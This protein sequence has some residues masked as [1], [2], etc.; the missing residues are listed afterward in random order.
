GPFNA[1]LYAPEIGDAAQSLGELLRF[2]GVLA[3]RLRELAILTV[4]AHWRAQYE[5]WAH[6]KIARVEGLEN[7]IIEA[8]KMGHAVAGDDGAEIVHLFVSELLKDR[9]VSDR[10]FQ[11]VKAELG[12]EALVE[13][14]VLVGY[15]GLIAA[16]LNVFQVPLPEGEEPPFPGE[17]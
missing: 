15:Y 12:D 1:F 9:N 14:V 16:T 13:L 10:T 2:H 17:V 3:G 5:W 4:A 8:V 7:G 11:A 6:A